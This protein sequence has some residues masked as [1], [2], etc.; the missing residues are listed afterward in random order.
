MRH[1]L[2]D[3]LK[4]KLHK[5]GNTLLQFGITNLNTLK[6]PPLLVDQMMNVS[7]GNVQFL[8]L[9]GKEW[10]F[11]EQGLFYAQQDGVVLVD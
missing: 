3:R 7:E 10:L 2:L 4:L 1:L 6:L 8:G 5:T 11:L 9:G